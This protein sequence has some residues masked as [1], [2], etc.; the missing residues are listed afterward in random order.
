MLQESEAALAAQL[1]SNAAASANRSAALA[2][3][4]QQAAARGTVDS[5][6]AV[7]AARQ[8][9]GAL[10]SAFSE[11]MSG[12]VAQGKASAADTTRTAEQSAETVRGETVCSLKFL[13]NLCLQGDSTISQDCTLSA[14]V[15]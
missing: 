10:L 3:A 5:L 1:E 4:A 13:E 15:K 2:T 14:T 6:P 7:A 11:A 12:I 8:A 9:Q